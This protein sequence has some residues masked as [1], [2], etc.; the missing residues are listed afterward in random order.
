MAFMNPAALSR[1]KTVQVTTANGAEV[2]TMLFDGVLRFLEEARARLREGDRAGFGERLSR[3]HAIVDELS[4]SLDRAHA[5]ELCETLDAL[6]GFSM[7]RITEA[8]LQR[9]EPMIDEVVRTLSPLR[10]AWKQL[11][12][13]QRQA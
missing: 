7:R 11:A 1:Y 13:S 12:G 4:V 6:Y 5:P 9:S 3:A 8:N 10:D 2:V